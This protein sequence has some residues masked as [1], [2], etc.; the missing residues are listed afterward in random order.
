A[1]RR[2]LELSNFAEFADLQIQWVHNPTNLI[3]S[4][5][6]EPKQKQSTNRRRSAACQRW[7]ENRCP[8]TA[9]NCNY[10]HVCS[11]CSSGNHVASDC[12][13]SKK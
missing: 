1:Q 10:L 11:K 4:Q 5:L 2:D 8:N 3:S 6:S 7:N 9:A 13:S 12:N